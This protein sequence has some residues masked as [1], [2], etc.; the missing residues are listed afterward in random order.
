M[1]E[2]NFCRCRVCSQ[3]LRRPGGDPPK[4]CFGSWV[5]YGPYLPRPPP[6]PFLPTH[7]TPPHPSPHMPPSPIPPQ[8][9]CIDPVAPNLDPSLSGPLHQSE[10][11]TEDS[12]LG[13]SHRP[14]GDSTGAFAKT[15][16]THAFQDPFAKEKQIDKQVIHK[17]DPGA[18]VATR[19][20]GFCEI[21]G[22]GG[23]IVRVCAPINGPRDPPNSRG[24]TRPAPQRPESAGLDLIQSRER[25]DLRGWT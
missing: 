16:G 8:T 25:P 20:R 4:G 24:W 12:I 5:G 19:R 22:P 10:T 14:G 7:P 2:W 13:G 17:G 23:P 18:P 11:L 3:I 6:V 15:Q 1:G 9:P 21:S